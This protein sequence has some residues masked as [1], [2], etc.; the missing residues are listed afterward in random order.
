MITE[1]L[2][3][4]YSTITFEREKEDYEGDT[5]EMETVEADVVI[6]TVG[7]NSRLYMELENG[8]Y[9]WLATE[10]TLKKNQEPTEEEMQNIVNKMLETVKENFDDEKLDELYNLDYADSAYWDRERLVNYILREQMI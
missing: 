6:L 3:T 2:Y 5:P 1:K 9:F 4:A 8:D 7:Q 10:T